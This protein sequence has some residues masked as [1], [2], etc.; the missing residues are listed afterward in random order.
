MADESVTT[1]TSDDIEGPPIFGMHPQPL[2]FEEE[3]EQALGASDGSIAGDLERAI[4]GASGVAAILARDQRSRS[5]AECS[6]LTYDGLS[7]HDR[8][9]LGLALEALHRSTSN[10]LERLRER[11]LDRTQKRRG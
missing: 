5:S 3:W 7:H 6:E 4:H 2:W 10:H 1:P 9:C 8:E 11:L